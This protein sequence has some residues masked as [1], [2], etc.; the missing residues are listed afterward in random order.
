MGIIREQYREDLRVLLLSK[1]FLKK[2][3]SGRP[4]LVASQPKEARRLCRVIRE[5]EKYLRRTDNFDISI[6][7]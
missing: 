5:H 2:L 6:G 3:V 7:K 1:N 4:D